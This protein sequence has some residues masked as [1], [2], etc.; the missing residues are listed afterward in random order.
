LPL[1]GALSDPVLDLYDSSGKLVASNDNWIANRLSII[2]S[3]LAPTSER[4]SAI[5]ATLQPGAYTATVRDSGNQPGLALVEVYD[6][7]PKSSLLAN[8][9]TRGK[10]ETA[11][12]VM[13]GGFIIGGA[14]PTKV[15]IRAIGPSLAA[16]GIVQPLADPVLELHDSSGNLISTN[17]N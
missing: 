5:L 4:E 14:D 8:I 2:G 16:K 7:D 9:S 3:Q 1:T 11:D 6:L 17:D 15:L 13:I 10:V 12:N